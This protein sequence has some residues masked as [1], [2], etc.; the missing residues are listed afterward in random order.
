MDLQRHL[1]DRLRDGVHSE[2]QGGDPLRRRDGLPSPSPSPAESA[3]P[4]PDA[5]GSPAPSPSPE[6]PPAPEPASIE[7]AAGSFAAFS[8]STKQHLVLTGL[9]EELKPGETVELTFDFGNGRTLKLDVPVGTPLSPAPRASA[10]TD[11]GEH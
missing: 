9:T 1:G 7:I 11:E 4:S 2:R 10:E 5:S 6:A 8:E 3:S